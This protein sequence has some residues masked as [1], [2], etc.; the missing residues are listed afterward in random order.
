MIF[1]LHF[2]DGYEFLEILKE[3]A[4]DNTKNPDLS[5]VWIDPDEFP[6]VR[7]YPIH[8]FTVFLCLKWNTS[9]NIVIVNSSAV[10]ILLGEDI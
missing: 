2:I 9:D 10:N 5:I 6:L 7:G 3:V 4:R 8:F 1:F